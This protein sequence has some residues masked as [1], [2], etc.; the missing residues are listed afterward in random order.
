MRTRTK[1]S[2]LAATTRALDGLL[3]ENLSLCGRGDRAWHS[4]AMRATLLAIMLAACGST[5][6]PPSP[7]VS[8]VAPRAPADAAVDAAPT[9]GDTMFAKMT[10]FAGKMCSCQDRACTDLVVQQMSTW[11]QEM[12][13]TADV[14]APVKMSEEDAKRMAV[15]TE[16][17]SKCM[18]DAMMKGTGSGTTP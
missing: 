14:R 16:R 17:F 18:T 6:P 11:A 15:I 12:A 7:P 13:T 5:T 9:S 4:R 8:N 10:E 3:T 2:P 1:T